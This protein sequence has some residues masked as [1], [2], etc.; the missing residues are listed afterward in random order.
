MNS[1]YSTPTMGMSFLARNK[2]NM[3][4][5]GIIMAFFV[6]CLIVAVI[7]EVQVARGEWTNNYFLSQDNMLIVLRQISI[8]GI[9]AIGMTFVIITAGVGLIGWLSPRSERYCSSAFC[10]HKCR[11][12]HW[13]HRKCRYDANDHRIRHWYHLWSH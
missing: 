6:L 5:Y 10:N 2:K 11:P 4:K 1:T 8:N 9:L 13:R 12:I 7:G 3:H